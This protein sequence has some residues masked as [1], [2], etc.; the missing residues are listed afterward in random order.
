MAFDQT[1]NHTEKFDTENEKY[2]LIQKIFVSYSS[3]LP[4]V[5]ISAPYLPNVIMRTHPANIKRR[6]DSDTEGMRTRT[7]YQPVTNS[8]RIMA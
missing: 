6:P 4:S 1:Q 8:T 7:R 2:T 3:F 5:Q